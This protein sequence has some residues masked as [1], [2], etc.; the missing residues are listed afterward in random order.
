MTNTGW[1]KPADA[2]ALPSQGTLNWKFILGGVL[3][4]GAVGYLIISGTIA[5]AAYFITVDDLM[6]SDEFTGQTVRITGAVIGDT[7][8]YDE[9]NLQI[10]FTI[11]HVPTETEDLGYALYLAANGLTEAKTVPVYIENQVKPDL[12]QH[13]AQAILSGQLGSDGVFYASELL[14]KC[15]SRFGEELPTHDQMDSAEAGSGA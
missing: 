8:V 4:L 7:I 3:L 14:L 11:A 10:N 6:S 1:E 13:E 15:P 2:A 5:G 12:L 9:E